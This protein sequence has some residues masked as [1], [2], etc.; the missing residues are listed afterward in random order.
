MKKLLWKNLWQTAVA[1]VFLLFVWLLAY[2]AAGNTLLVPPLGDCLREMGELLLSSAF[3]QGVGGSVFRAFVAFLLSFIFA[4]FF[5][6]I[7]YMAPTF[8]GIFAPVASA[9]RSLP[10]L[11]I[12]LILLT[13]LKAAQAPVAVAFLS[14]FPML[15]TGV[16]AA[17]SGIDKNLIDMARVCG[18]S[19]RR[20]I[21][22]VYLPLSSPYILREVG[23]ALSFSVKLIVS[24]EILANT[25][26]SLGG[27]MQEARVYSEVARLFALVGVAFFIGLLFEIALSFLVVLVEKKIK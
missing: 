16:L 3:W 7:A 19:S 5:A 10:V 15:Y 8:A 18:T 13:F 23:G 2:L 1:I 21:F 14:L 22:E 4:L 9:L 27:M 20:R 11:A 6:V 17:L 25:A 24:A 26:R 12:L